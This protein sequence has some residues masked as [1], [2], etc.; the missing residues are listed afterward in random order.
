M[1]YEPAEDTQLLLLTIQHD[2]YDELLNKT[3]SLKIC[4]VGCGSGEIITSLAKEF[5][6]NL[7]YAT[8]INPQAI[9]DTQDLAKEKDVKVSIEKGSFLEP[10]ENQIFDTI[11][12]NTPYL[13]CE[14]GDRF[15]KLSIEDKA[16]YGGR[17]GCEVTNNFVD[18]L[19]KSIHEN[20]NIY[21]LISSLTQPKLVEENLKNNAFE[22]EVIAKE[23]HFFEELLIYK[24]QPNEVLTHLLNSNYTNIKRFD[25]GKHSYIMQAQDKYSNIVMVK[26][27]RREY[28]S[29]EIYYLKKLQDTQYAPQIVEGGY[30]FI[31]Y[32]KVEGL[33]IEK[34][35][36]LCKLN[37][38]SL[39]EIERVF[40]RVFE[41]CYDLDKKGICK[42]EMTHPTEHIYIDPDE[43]DE[44]HFI[45]FER[46]SMSNR[47]ENTRQFLQ[48]VSKSN[49]IF[50]QFN[51]T[52][53]KEKV[54]QLG[55]GINQDLKQPINLK[56]LY[57]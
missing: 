8:D 24:I 20:T 14:E 1:T 49:Y 56:N 57:K 46:S 30:N 44:I 47:F 13:P 36:E 21:M 48:F 11:F 7:Y 54:I 39:K 27:G 50:E 34:F 51:I 26:F 41:I 37:K 33:T 31:V 16:I 15:N 2:L 45:D 38:Y 28:I 19:H 29:K 3:N 9:T 22:Y 40:N 10:F 53:S 17:V 6:N 23:N 12:F 43:L 18:S 25:K 55:K 52:I 35:L 4:E 5:S 42:D 32:K